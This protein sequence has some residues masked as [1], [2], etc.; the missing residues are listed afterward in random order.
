MLLGWRIIH[1][2]IAAVFPWV[3]FGIAYSKLRSTDQELIPFMQ[4]LYWVAASIAAVLLFSSVL[5]RLSGP[6]A[7]ATVPFCFFWV[8]TILLG[9]SLASYYRP[10]GMCA[11]GP[12]DCWPGFEV[13]LGVPILV[14]A[15]AAVISSVVINGFRGGS[16]R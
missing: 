13:I 8:C 16:N 7:A 2:V 14:M 9:T 12:A 4:N 10:A 11:T 6:S 15:S 3:L 5:L 1:A